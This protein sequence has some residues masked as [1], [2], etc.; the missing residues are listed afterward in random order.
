MDQ[1]MSEIQVKDAVARG[2]MVFEQMGLE[3]DIKSI[4]DPN[5]ADEVEEARRQF[6]RLT[7]EK[8]FKAY[9]VTGTNGETGERMPSFEATA[10]RVVFVPAMQGG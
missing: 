10:G 6:E 3:G 8:K 5:S 4:W 7:K 1:T 9:R 2:A